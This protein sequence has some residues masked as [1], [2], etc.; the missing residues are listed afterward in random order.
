M[1]KIGEILRELTALCDSVSLQS[2]RTWP[3]GPFIPC[4]NCGRLNNPNGLYCGQC[5][6]RRDAC[7]GILAGLNAS[8]LP[9]NWELCD[10][11]SHEQALIRQRCMDGDHVRGE[12]VETGEGYLG[13]A[14]LEVG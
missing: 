4:M 5:F 12:Q 10:K 14:R 7:E 6:H 9:K 3:R 1:E 8:Y 11:L 13:L 2:K